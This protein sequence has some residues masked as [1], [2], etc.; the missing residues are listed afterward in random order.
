MRDCLG[1][2][3]WHPVGFFSAEGLVK[4]IGPADSETIVVGGG[5]VTLAPVNAAKQA[6]VILQQPLEVPDRS[7]KTLYTRIFCV[8]SIYAYN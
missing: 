8:N 6:L 1:E 5:S 2:G 7:V 3:F 4:I